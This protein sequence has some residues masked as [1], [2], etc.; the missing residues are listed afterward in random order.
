VTTLLRLLHAH[1][2]SAERQKVVLRAWLVDNTPNR[3]LRFS[4][5]SN[6]YGLL[7]D[8]T[9]DLKGVKRPRLWK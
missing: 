9:D 7:L 1:D 8:E 4:L 5:R 6:G 3:A 2:A